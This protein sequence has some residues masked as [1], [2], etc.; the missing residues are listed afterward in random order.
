MYQEEENKNKMLAQLLFKIFK[1]VLISG[2][3]ILFF[4]IIRFMMKS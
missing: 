2:L 4:F 3:I 1:T